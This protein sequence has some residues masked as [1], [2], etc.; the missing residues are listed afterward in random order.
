M[1]T[2]IGPLIGMGLPVG[3][4][5]I[6]I[7]PEAT[8]V[9]ADQVTN[10]ADRGDWTIEIGPDNTRLLALSEQSCPVK[11]TVYCVPEKVPLPVA[12]RHPG[13]MGNPTMIVFT[14]CWSI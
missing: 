10:P 1:L 14:C 7:D 8:R 6:W 12:G 11:F 13:D 5:G 2:T 4:A 3:G 9:P